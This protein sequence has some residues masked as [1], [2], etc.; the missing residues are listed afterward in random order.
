MGCFWRLSENN[1]LFC[2]CLPPPGPCLS[3]NVMDRRL[4][5]QNKTRS[6]VLSLCIFILTQTFGPTS[7]WTERLHHHAVKQ[8]KC[9]MLPC[10]V[11]GSEYN[12]CQWSISALWHSMS[13][14][15]EFQFHRSQGRT[16]TPP[17]PSVFIYFFI[18]PQPEKDCG[19]LTWRQNNTCL[20]SRVNS[21]RLRSSRLPSVFP[22]T[23]QHR[24]SPRSPGRGSGWWWRHGRAA[25]GSP[26]QADQ[27]WAHVVKET[28]QHFYKWFE[29]TNTT[30]HTLPPRPERLLECFLRTFCALSVFWFF[31]CVCDFAGKEWCSFR[32][33]HLLRM[34]LRRLPLVSCVIRCCDGWGRW[35]HVSAIGVVVQGG[36]TLVGPLWP[37]IWWK[38]A[39]L[40]SHICV[41]IVFVVVVEGTPPPFDAIP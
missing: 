10:M 31:F 6:L 17:Q 37:N 30:K 18:F 38:S 5:H 8:E 9:W 3:R 41:V 20:W 25:H 35:R 24:H 13:C 36:G 16:G 23:R 14:L 2:R 21:R 11:K 34:L 28:R 7:Q 40:W 15:R 33:V 26:H 32:G 19:S 1:H 22:W 27:I 12:S 39:A 4:I 29:W